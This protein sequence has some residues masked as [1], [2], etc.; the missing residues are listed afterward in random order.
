MNTPVDLGLGDAGDAMDSLE[1]VT[2]DGVQWPEG[3][4]PADLPPPVSRQQRRSEERHGAA[5]AAIIPSPERSS[6]FFPASAFGGRPVPDREWLVPDLIPSKNV[7]LLSGD[8]GTGKSLLAL[9]LSVAVVAECQWLGRSVKPGRV[10]FITAEDD[11]DELH[12]RIE[13]I[14]RA[15][16]LPPM[17]RLPG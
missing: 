1:E 8:G 16:G 14:R 5:R 13:D 6:H 12:R 10:I 4:G 9:M 15:Y 3:Q 7:T 11:E 2:L 17:R